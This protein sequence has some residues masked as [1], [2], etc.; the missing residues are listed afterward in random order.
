MSKLSLSQNP[1][2]F[3]GFL[4][5]ALVFLFIVDPI[6]A[7][8]MNT[9]FDSVFTLTDILAGQ[10]PADSGFSSSWLVSFLKVSVLFL[11]NLSEAVFFYGFIVAFIHGISR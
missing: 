8:V 2:G 6:E 10:V 11:Y 7:C 4:L 3:I 1:V 9:L 5:T